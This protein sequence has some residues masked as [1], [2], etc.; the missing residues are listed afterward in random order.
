MNSERKEG[1]KR[2]GGGGIEG[3]GREEG[4]VILTHTPA[5]YFDFVFVLPW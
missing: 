2:G 5:E 3:K 4:E 1:D